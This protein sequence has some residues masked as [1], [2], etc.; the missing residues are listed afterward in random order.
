MQAIPLGSGVHSHELR[1]TARH[2][3]D[4]LRKSLNRPQN[5]L[6][7]VAAISDRQ[8]IWR[9]AEPSAPTAAKPARRAQTLPQFGV[10]DRPRRAHIANESKEERLRPPAS[11]FEHSTMRGES[12]LESR[13]TPFR[14]TSS[15]AKV[16]LRSRIDSGPP[17]ERR[18]TVNQQSRSTRS[19]SS[20]S[21]S[22]ASAAAATRQH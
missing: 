11:F 2:L 1:K 13:Y 8:M 15:P 17:S 21:L 10:I 4:G 3:V 18:T 12:P 5:G 19:R 6:S 20:R 22:E 7:Q 9:P 16:T 14:F